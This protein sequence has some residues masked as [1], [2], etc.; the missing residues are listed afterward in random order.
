[1]ATKQPQADDK[2]KVSTVKLAVGA[3]SLFLFIVGLK[4]TFHVDEARGT[5]TTEE[6]GDGANGDARARSARAR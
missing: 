5:R 3:A 1:M 6:E 2:S 4:R